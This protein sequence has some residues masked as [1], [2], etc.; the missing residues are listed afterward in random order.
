MKMYPKRVKVNTKDAL[1][2]TF[3]VSKAKLD[4]HTEY[5]DAQGK[6]SCMEDTFPNN[7]C[8][9][10]EKLNTLSGLAAEQGKNRLHVVCE[11]T[12]GYENK[13]LRLAHSLGHGTSYVSGESVSKYKVVES[14]DTG[15]T[16]EK[17][18]RV[19]MVLAK[20]DKMLTCRQLKGEYLLLRECNR[21]Y[22]TEL[23]AYSQ[24]KGQI[25]FVLHDLFCDYSFQ[26][27]F[28]YDQT[29]RTLMKRFSCNPYRII[30]AGYDYFFTYMKESNKEIR[31]GTL[32]RLWENAQSSTMICRDN[33]LL[34][35]LEEHLRNLWEEFLL[36]EE[37]L[38]SIRQRMTGFYERLRQKEAPVPQP[39][40]GLI[41]DFHVAR[42]LGETGPLTDFPNTR[43]LLRYAGLN[44]RERKSG[45]YKG[46]VRISKKGRAP[47]RNVLALTVLGLVKKNALFGPYYHAK[48]AAGMKGSKIMV[49]VMRKFLK[50]FFALSKPNTQ[51]DAQRL[52]ICENQYA[53]KIAA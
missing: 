43:I 42:I 48:K 4:F 6:L 46:L 30:N 33:E 3:D 45:L 50:V 29:G 36:H 7:N 39:Q 51:F 13:L 12:G 14:N 26:K 40:K 49:A 52:F 27:D 2:V 19:M 32:K 20:L 15:K 53:Y 24:V 31:N 47:L 23:K 35:L 25:H 9:I 34:L 21:I 38:A 22:D 11:S 1:L 28:L 16:D 17:D 18:P 37:R 8:A 10:K 5:S 44:L 41:N